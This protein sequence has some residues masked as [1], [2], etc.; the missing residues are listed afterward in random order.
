MWSLNDFNFYPKSKKL[1]QIPWRLQPMDCRNVGIGQKL[2]IGSGEESGICTSPVSTQW[3]WHIAADSVPFTAPAS[4]TRLHVIAFKLKHKRF[5][6]VLCKTLA[7]LKETCLAFVSATPYCWDN[8]QMHAKL[9]RRKLRT[10]PLRCSCVIWTASIL[11]NCNEKEMLWIVLHVIWPSLRRPLIWN[12]CCPFKSP[13]FSHLEKAHTVFKPLPPSIPIVRTETFENVLNCGRLL[14]LI[15]L[16]NNRTYWCLFKCWTNCGLANVNFLSKFSFIME[17]CWPVQWQWRTLKV[18]LLIVCSF[19]RL[20]VEFLFSSDQYCLSLFISRSLCENSQL[21]GKYLVLLY[22]Q[23]K[24]NTCNKSEWKLRCFWYFSD[25]WFSEA[26]QEIVLS[27]TD[28]ESGRVR[29]Q[30]PV[31]MHLCQPFPERRGRCIVSESKRL[32]CELVGRVQKKGEHQQNSFL[33]LP[34]NWITFVFL[35]DVKFNLA[36]NLKIKIRSSTM[37]TVLCRCVARKFDEGNNNQF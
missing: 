13:R 12:R 33:P 25:I 8:P 14:T 5:T 19:D 17:F 31:Q 23:K 16:C 24:S 6:S 15:F 34:Y 9:P 3:T 36:E 29:N 32:C 27:N 10:K 2:R 4:P 11:K 21:S 7:Y 35:F 37:K 22:L 28:D 26:V 30:A 20:Q 1:F 18:A